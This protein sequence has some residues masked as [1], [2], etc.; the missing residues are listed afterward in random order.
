MIVDDDPAVRQALAF[1]VELEGYAVATCA[2]A[3]ALLAFDLPATR[4]CLVIDERLPDGSGLKALAQLRAAGCQLPA[5]M[6]TSHPNRR[7]RQ[8]AHSAGAPVLEKPLIED[9]L[10]GWIRTV[11]PL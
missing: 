11:A 10:I 6:I 2:G 7:F 9:G 3:A 4:A 1:T 5:A 8:A